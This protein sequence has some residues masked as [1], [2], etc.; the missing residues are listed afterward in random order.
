MGVGE[1]VGVPDGVPVGDGTAVLVG[2]GETV[3]TVKKA[4]EGILHDSPGIVKVIEIVT[5]LSMKLE[6][7]AT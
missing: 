2:V 3:I 6:L 7:M 1:P 4:A 5:S